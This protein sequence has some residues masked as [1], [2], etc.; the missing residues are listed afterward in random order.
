MTFK[1]LLQRAGISK[2]ELA[3]R[4]GITPTTVSE[5]GAKPK[6]YA[7]AYLELLIEFNR[8]RP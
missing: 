3:K 8:Y 1:E 4:L 6:H 5:W 7:V 2:T